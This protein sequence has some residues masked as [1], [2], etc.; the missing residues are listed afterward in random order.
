MPLD[1]AALLGCGVITGAG[2]AINSAAVRFGDTVC[3]IGCGGVGLSCV[4][5]AAI[6]GAERIIAVDTNPPKLALSRRFGATDTIDASGPDVVEGVLA[7]TGGA[8]VHHSFEV[9][10][11]ART[12][13]QALDVL[14]RGGVAY[15]IGMQRPGTE[16]VVDPFA[17]LV[18]RQ[19]G[20][21][22]VYMGATN[23][24]RDIPAYVRLYLDGRFNLDDLVSQRIALEQINDAYDDLAAGRV[25]RSVITF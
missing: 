9:V 24:K 12:A 4:Q 25:I 11:S 3:V 2:A 13:R 7:L 18:L 10:E 17:D 8:G 16:L 21:Q 22:G 14:R 15:I 23:F 5:G 1:R 20:I 19:R 6:C